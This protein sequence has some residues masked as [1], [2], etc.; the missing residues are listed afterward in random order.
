MHVILNMNR[1]FQLPILIN[2]YAHSNLEKLVC[3][4][5]YA[6]CLES[7]P[8]VALHSMLHYKI[9]YAKFLRPVITVKILVQYEQISNFLQSIQ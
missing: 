5:H 6:A 8:Q 1:N 7:Q 9:P 3:K 2:Y 4:E